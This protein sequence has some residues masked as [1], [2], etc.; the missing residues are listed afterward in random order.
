M[1]GET[2]PNNLRFALVG[3]LALT[4]ATAL[5]S[6]QA[7]DK[8]DK[9][10]DSKTYKLAY[11]F[12]AK[13]VDTYKLR[14]SAS[15]TGMMAIKLKGEMQLEQTGLSYDKDKKVGQVEQNTKRVKMN[16]DM[17]GSKQEYD[18]ENPPADPSNNMLA[19]AGQGMLGKT[20]LDVQQ[21]GKIVKEKS[22]KKASNSPLASMLGIK[23]LPYDIFRMPAKEIKVGDSW[24]HTS[25]SKRKNAMGQE[26]SVKFHF[27]YTLKR[28]SERNGE[29]IA[30][31]SFK[32]KPEMANI[33]GGMGAKVEKADGSGM[34]SFNISK[35]HLR[36]INY[37]M[38]IEATSSFGE[39]D[40][41]KAYY[42]TSLTMRRAKKKDAK[43]AEK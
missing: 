2:M 21:D 4:C 18:S 19:S 28:I 10:T 1:L 15:Q 29:V 36:S 38:K 34:A 26:E 30:S 12:S 5:N 23:N 14:L 13:K 20:T 39:G 42:K 22:Q 33:P 11:K 17:N 43:K 6:V 25:V 41:A 31:V 16:F 32:I 8:P 40:D 24:K 35:G 27:T 9:T 37:S 3:A 7:Q